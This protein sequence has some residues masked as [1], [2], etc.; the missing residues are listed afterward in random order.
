MYI[1]L[2]NRFYW[3]TGQAERQNVGY[4]YPEQ[5][6]LTTSGS[7]AYLINDLCFFL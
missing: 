4:K 5:W 7:G 6:N 3:V 2:E 1:K